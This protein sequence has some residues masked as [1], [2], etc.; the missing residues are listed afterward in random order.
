MD[1]TKYIFLSNGQKGGVATF[2]NDHINYLSQTK[3]DLLLIDN[4]PKQTY[5]NLNKKI[6]LHKFKKNKKK[7]NKILNTGS[8]NKTLFITNYAF[9]IRYYFILRNFRKK[10]NQIILTIHSGLLTLNLR[11][12]LA[13]LL[14]SLIYQNT[15]FLFFGSKSAKDWWKKK[16]P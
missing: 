13:G 8:K 15:D 5:D 1:R 12:Y 7:L 9:L 4:N 14:F 2:I 6:T 3:K 10:K 11:T 16:Y